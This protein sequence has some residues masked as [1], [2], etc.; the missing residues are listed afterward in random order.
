VR[1][2]TGR[3]SIQVIVAIQHE[4]RDEA[5]AQLRRRL[6]EWMMEDID[7]LGASPLTGSLLHYTVL[8]HRCIGETARGSRPIHGKIRG[9]DSAGG[10]LT[11]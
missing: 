11:E 4:N 1:S 3:Y 7:G 5:V 9:S 10:C 6:A 2:N 8:S